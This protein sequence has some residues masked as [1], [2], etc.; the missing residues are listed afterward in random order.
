MGKSERTAAPVA[1][2]REDAPRLRAASSQT[3]A[4]GKRGAYSLPLATGAAVLSLLPILAAVDHL[5]GRVDL[6]SDAP[7]ELILMVADGQIPLGSLAALCLLVGGLIG[8]VALAGRG[9]ADLDI[10]PI[11]EQGADDD[12]GIEG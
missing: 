7:W 9:H 3:W 4:A 1:R 6:G 10:F 8:T 5:A 12:L 11:A 2:G